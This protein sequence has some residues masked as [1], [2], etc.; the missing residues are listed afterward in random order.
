MSSCVYYYYKDPCHQS[1]CFKLLQS[2]SVNCYRPVRQLYGVTAAFASRG[3]GLQTGG[4]FSNFILLC[5]THWHSKLS[6]FVVWLEKLCILYV[7]LCVLWQPVK[8]CATFFS[9]WGFS[10]LWWWHEDIYIKTC[11]VNFLGVSE[12]LQNGCIVLFLNKIIF[13]ICLCSDI[14]IYVLIFVPVNHSRERG[15]I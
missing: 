8:Q 12:V 4:P 3:G 11:V 15:V 2:C 5:T 10:S 6:L 9:P 7:L 13:S 1:D 14:D